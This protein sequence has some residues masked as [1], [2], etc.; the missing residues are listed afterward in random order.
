MHSFGA[1]EDPYI[2]SCLHRII[3]LEESD[4]ET[5]HLLV[6]LFMQFLSR[7][8]QAF[9]TE[10]K[11]TARVQV[12]VLRHLYLLL[13]YSQIEKTFHVTPS[14]LRSS[15]VFNAFVSNLPQM[16]DQNHL[17]GNHLLPVA[18]QILLYSP[19][20]ANVSSASQENVPITYTYTL[21][22]MEPHVR[23]SWLMAVEV[24]M[25][26]YEYTQPPFS[27]QI[28][29]LIRLILNSLEAQFHRCKRI[30]AT[31]V[32]DI[33]PSARSRDLS[34]PS[35]NADLEEK[36]EPTPPISPLFVA[37]STS[38]GTSSKGKQGLFTQ[39]SAPSFSRKYQD[40]SLD[41]DDTESELVAI[42]ESDLSDSTLHN[43]SAPVSK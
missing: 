42:P 36:A 40:S 9:P 4:K 1:S 7:S 12:I 10:E 19:S 31:I 26:K 28:S 18:L 38:Q 2:T 30:P 8:D 34:Q 25:Y 14:R 29:N 11:P 22:R 17:M 35:V 13:G 43:S 6:F 21:W 33:Q 41:A 20:P 27:V 23:R 16:L 3:D 5:I 32:M 37:E 15:A 39:K 24:I